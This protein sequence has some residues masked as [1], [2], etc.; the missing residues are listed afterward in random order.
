MESEHVDNN[1]FSTVR[2]KREWETL[3]K[4]IIPLSSALLDGNDP[5]KLVGIR[6][7]NNAFFSAIRGI[8]LL[9]EA[10]PEFQYLSKVPSYLITFTEKTSFTTSLG[11]IGTRKVK[12][13]ER[14]K[15]NRFFNMWETEF[16]QNRRR[17]TA[18]GFGEDYRLIGRKG[19]P[20]KGDNR[21]ESPENNSLRSNKDGQTVRG[22]NTTE[23]ENIEAGPVREGSIVGVSANPTASPATSTGP[24][25]IRGVF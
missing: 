21:R 24:W 3:T 14:V 19:T 20:E 18:N 10:R 22:I 5:E 15:C 12:E 23:L 25:P 2:K 8:I 1:S 11:D 16:L 17:T 13:S 6:L 4:N 9:G 7:Y